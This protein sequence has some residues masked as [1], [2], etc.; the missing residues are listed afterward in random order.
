MSPPAVVIVWACRECCWV[1]PAD[2]P[3]CGICGRNRANVTACPH[4]L[5]M[6]A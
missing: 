3:Y 2:R 5:R 4:P 6:C 1:W